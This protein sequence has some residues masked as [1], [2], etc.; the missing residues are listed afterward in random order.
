MADLFWLLAAFRPERDPELIQLFNDLAWVTFTGQVGFLV[1]QSAFLALAIYLDRQPRRVFAPWVAHF[2]LL[3]AAALAPAAFCALA[4]D[5][6]IAWNGLLSFWV[7]NLAIAAW[8]V[9]MTVVLGQTLY[10]Q[11]RETGAAA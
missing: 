8:I 9:V 11:R 6:P 5:G 2:N 7:K 3:V 1:A 4:L 10:R